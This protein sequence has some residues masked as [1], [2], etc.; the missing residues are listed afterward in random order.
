[1]DPKRGSFPPWRGFQWFP[2]GEVRSARAFSALGWSL[3]P[4]SYPG[5][6]RSNRSHQ[7]CCEV[8]DRRHSPEIL[9]HNRSITWYSWVEGVGLRLMETVRISPDS[10][11]LSRPLDN[12]LSD[13]EPDAESVDSSEDAS[14]PEAALPDIFRGRMFCVAHGRQCYRGRTFGGETVWICPDERH[15]KPL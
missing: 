3:L 2:R 11:L 15:S 4:S 9:R 14:L 6:S 5:P 10:S 13:P 12:P 1:M 7:G 8:A